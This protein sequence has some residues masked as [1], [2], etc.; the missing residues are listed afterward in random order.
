MI[1]F[2]GWV[3]ISFRENDDSNLLA[4]KNRIEEL[5]IHNQKFELNDFNGNLTL[6]I[7]GCHNHDNGYSEDIHDFLI[8]IS[9]IAKDS[10]GLIYIRLPEHIMKFNEFIIYKLAKGNVS[11]QEDK[12][13]SPCNPIIE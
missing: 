3:I 12:L 6:T 11:I 13:L 8:Q 1:E 9:K 2:N 10:Y 5:N 4:I 7:N